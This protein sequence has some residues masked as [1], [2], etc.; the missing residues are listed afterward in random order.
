MNCNNHYTGLGEVPLCAEAVILPLIADTTG[1]WAFMSSFNGAYQYKQFQ[2]TE[3]EPIIVPVSLNENYNYTF[4]LYKPNN[5]I[6]NN[7]Y[8]AM[9]T[10]PF[11]PDIDNP[12]TYE[13]S[14]IQH[15]GKRQITATNEQA[16][17]MEAS[18]INA[19]QIAVFVEGALRQAGTDTD[20][21]SFTSITGTVTFNTPLIEGQKI[22]ILYF[23]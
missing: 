5:S 21:Y 14:I 4:R 8:Y 15:T 16:S 7:T 18:L 12:V 11:L 3:G 22:T 1:T 19:K 23:K 2:C 6:L 17:I 20:E 9:H 13:N 10:I